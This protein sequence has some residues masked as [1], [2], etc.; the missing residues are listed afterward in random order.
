MK[1]G[2]RRSHTGIRRAEEDKVRKSDRVFPTCR[3]SPS[4]GLIGD[5]SLCKLLLGLGQASMTVLTI[6]RHFQ[7]SFW[8]LTRYRKINGPRYRL[9]QVTADVCK[10][11]DEIVRRL[12]KRN[13]LIKYLCTDC[14]AGHNHNHRTFFPEW[15]L[16]SWHGIR[17]SRQN[18][19]FER[20]VTFGNSFA[21][22]STITLGH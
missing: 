21:T 17:A 1:Y 3:R 22:E 6:H 7:W 19:H 13:R 15:H 14:D 5:N 18:S 10:V 9:F 16:R 4:T 2:E 11:L 8:D 20:S 12:S